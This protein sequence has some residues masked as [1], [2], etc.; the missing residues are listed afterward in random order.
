MARHPGRP[1]AARLS[2]LL[3][4]HAIGTT[5]TT[6]DF[7]ELLIG[8]C[9]DFGITRPRCQEPIGRYRPDFAWPDRKLIVEADSWESHG[10]RKAFEA[11]RRKDAELHAM[12]W[13]VLRFTHRQMTRDREWVARMLGR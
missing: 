11:D 5:A 13:T 12:G 4:E 2:A 10:T 1:G 7:E 3:S 8:I 6:N 9:D